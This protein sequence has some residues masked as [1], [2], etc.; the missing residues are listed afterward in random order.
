MKMA[1]RTLVMLCGLVLVLSACAGGQRNGEHD[2][3]A[4][5]HLQ[6]GVH[7]MRQ[8]NLSAA[9]D[10]LEKSLEFDNRNAM[11]HSSIALLYDS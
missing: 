3:A 11:T 10:N 2:E 9:K 5:S 8:G 1:I 4:D 7:Y 6:L